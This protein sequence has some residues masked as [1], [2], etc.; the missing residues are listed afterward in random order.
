[1]QKV[2]F[3]DFVFENKEDIRLDGCEFKI[4]P[5]VTTAD[6]IINASKQADIL[7]MR[8]QGR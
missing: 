1:M 5:P 8:D 2:T 7:L 6:Q 4:F 3:L